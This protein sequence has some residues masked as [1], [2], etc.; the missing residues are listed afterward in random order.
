MR[1]AVVEKTRVGVSNPIALVALQ[2]FKIFR[3]IIYPCPPPLTP[4]W[5]A[6]YLGA[7]ETITSPSGDKLSVDT[8]MIELD[9]QTAE[10]TFEPSEEERFAIVEAL[11]GDA[12][13]LEEAV[14]E[15]FASMDTGRLKF[16]AKA[17]A[18]TLKERS[19]EILRKTKEEEEKARKQHRARLR[20]IALLEKAYL[21]S[22]TGRR[23]NST[24][25][26]QNIAAKMYDGGAR[27]PDPEE[28]SHEV[29]PV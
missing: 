24:Q 5:T 11:L 12:P 21:A 27:I 13:P 6:V 16:I 25:A 9:T 2:I 22:Q 4:D 19:A 3:V 17:A 1:V 20:Q 23:A 29:N 10:V 15:D 7:M 8:G 28:G 14:D 26:S 18:T